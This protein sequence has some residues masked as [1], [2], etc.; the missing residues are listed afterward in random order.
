[1]SSGLDAYGFPCCD[2]T[3]C[4]PP[5]APDEAAERSSRWLHVALTLSALC[6]PSPRPDATATPSASPP[7]PAPPADAD[8][9]DT[10]ERDEDHAAQI[11][12]DLPRTLPSNRIVSGPAVQAALRRIL[13]R[14]VSE[15]PRMGY[16]QS[17]SDVAAVAMLGVS[18]AAEPDGVCED[19]AY[20]LLRDM[21][22][23]MGADFYCPSLTGVQVECRVLE[24]LARQHSP[25]AFRVLRKGGSMFMPTTARW[26]MCVFA[27]DFAPRVLF[28]VWDALLRELMPV[29]EE[30]R[31]RTTAERHRAFVS[32]LLG[33]CLA[34]LDSLP[35]VPL[36]PGLGV[37]GALKN[38][39]EY[40]C[41]DMETLLRRA[42]EHA[43]ALA[44]CDI[45][46]VRSR[47]RVQVLEEV[48]N[49]RSIRLV[50][51]LERQTL[52][53]R[54][55]LDALRRE[56]EQAGQDAIDF[57]TF[58]NVVARVAPEW[59]R[60]AAVVASL[61]AAL[62]KD[63]S[64]ELDFHGMMVG[65]SPLCRGSFRD[66]LAAIFRAIDLEHKGG[67]SRDQLL[68][69][70][71]GSGVFERVCRTD[72]NQPDLCTPDIPK[73]DSEQSETEN[74]LSHAKTAE[75]Y[76]DRVF[77]SLDTE[78]RGFIT[79]EDFERIVM[80]EPVLVSIF[81]RTA[82]Y[83]SSVTTPE[84]HTA[85]KSEPS[86]AQRLGLPSLV[87]PSLVPILTAPREVVKPCK[88]Q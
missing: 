21:S 34:V 40:A 17:M 1:M 18:A 76:V 59:S 67:I 3:Y 80:V 50:S 87:P 86:L 75:D 70:I 33:V 25:E 9:S 4:G 44:D 47:V 29:D 2:A 83:S 52:F 42:D 68:L 32:R 23:A 38:A 27:Q 28:S 82:S 46:A 48:E 39:P 64:G 41:R 84:E 62:D 37:I 16:T 69:L 6:S 43:R 19:A 24:A 73:S 63:G 85:P 31:E 51:Q 88:V 53:A 13:V 54:E 7:P 22:R 74:A 12:A 8:R 77:R 56:F 35:S 20:A 57:H 15:H 30:L 11:E 26:L 65:L 71:E 14:F 5:I 61:F 81:F 36:V 49:V 78:H 60:N 10:S 55:E 58:H 79:L 66:K 45:D 72:S